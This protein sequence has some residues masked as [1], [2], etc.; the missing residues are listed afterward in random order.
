MARNRRKTLARRKKQRRWLIPKIL[1]VLAC[2]ALIAFIGVIFFMEK[3]LQ[4]VGVF[5]TARA[6]VREMVKPEQA[7]APPPVFEELTPEER[8]LLDDIVRERS[9]R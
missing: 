7:Q 6:P 8:Q 3:K 1:L 5:G 4:H 9:P 2:T